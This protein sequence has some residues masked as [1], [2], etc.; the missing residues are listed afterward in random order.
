MNIGI[1]SIEIALCLVLLPAIALTR[2][3]ARRWMLVALI[4]VA[5]GV[6]LTPADVVSAVL[7]AAI[8][9]VT[10]ALGVRSATWFHAAPTVDAK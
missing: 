9:S 10:F 6:V 4:S 3:I 2:G 5:V 8:L 1:G 7:V